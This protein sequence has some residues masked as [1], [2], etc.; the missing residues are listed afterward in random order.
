[1]KGP[2][3]TPGSAGRPRLPASDA[4]PFSSNRR[5]C[6][7]CGRECLRPRD[8]APLLRFTQSQ[9]LRTLKSCA[10]IVIVSVKV[11]LLRRWRLAQDFLTQNRGSSDNL[12][13]IVGRTR[14][15]LNRDSFEYT[16][17][18]E[19]ASMLKKIA[20]VVS[21]MLLGVCG[22]SAVGWLIGR[23][24]YFFAVELPYRDLHLPPGQ[25]QAATC[26]LSTSIA[27][28][29]L[30]LVMSGVVLGLVA[31]FGIGMWHTDESERADSPC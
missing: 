13:A 1:M 17:R 24:I 9:P 2:A 7:T 18:R 3:D 15:K 11:W 4:R 28:L 12:E 20:I 10:G 29:T 22:G 26:G 19:N 16:R 5:S 8:V 6:K 27:I 23:S 25:F 30:Y 21:S 14:P 31:G